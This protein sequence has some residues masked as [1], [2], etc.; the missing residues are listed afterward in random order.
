MRHKLY[1]GIDIGGTKIAAAIVSEKGKILARV[2][3]PTPPHARPQTILKVLRTTLKNLL[4]EAGISKKQICGI[5]IGV[6]G[7]VN[8][9][10]TE[11]LRTPNI[12]LTHFP[13]ARALKKT[14][15]VPILLGNDVNVGLLGEHWLGVG[16]GKKDIVSLFLGTGVGGGIIAHGQLLTGAKGFAAE[17]GHM[18]MDIHGPLCH[19]GNHGCLE[20][21]TSRWAIERDIR[22]AI[23]R[24]EKTLISELTNGKLATIKSKTLK[25][26]LNK[27]D[28]V[29][30]K[31]MR[32]VAKTIGSAC[33]SLKHILNPE[34]IILGGGVIEA[35]GDFILP[36]VQKEIKR[37]PF[38]AKIDPCRIANA[39]LTDDAVILGA[40]ALVKHQD[41]P[42]RTK[43]L[44]QKSR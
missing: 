32:K 30:T 19:C 10:G 23:K 26:A 41:K 34:L 8:P 29:T 38:F 9:G 12:A 11:I 7:L 3:E 42:T 5:G 35:C 18:T 6:P 17:L 33:I 37:D 31:I 1:I 28:A 20:A 44:S 13:L 2:K 40:V 22:Q 36:I 39:R 14:F 24:G 4:S 25:K 16:R 15:S 27:H 21:L 43:S